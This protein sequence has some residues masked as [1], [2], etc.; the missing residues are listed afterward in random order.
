MRKKR[1]TLTW[2]STEAVTLHTFTKK[3]ARD[4]GP[5]LTGQ[6]TTRVCKNI[7][8]FNKMLLRGAIESIGTVRKSPQSS[9]FRLSLFH[10]LQI[11]GSSKQ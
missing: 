11:L 2:N 8:S 3:E 10:R 4:S 7:V 6:P 1:S 5:L 9:Q